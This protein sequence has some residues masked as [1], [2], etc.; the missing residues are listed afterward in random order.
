MLVWG[1]VIE[2]R[3]LYMLGERSTTE[4]YP[5]PHVVLVLVRD[6]DYQ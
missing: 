5:L 3:V 4:P 1:R 6:R 2:L